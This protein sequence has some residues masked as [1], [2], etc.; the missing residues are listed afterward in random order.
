LSVLDSKTGQYKK[1]TFVFDKDYTTYQI[2]IEDLASPELNIT[3]LP[4]G[5]NV[6]IPADGSLVITVPTSGVRNEITDAKID[7][8]MELTHWENRVL[9]IQGSKIWAISLKP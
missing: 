5:V 3:L 8:T 1:Y 6:E 7:S 2:S 9:G 4:K